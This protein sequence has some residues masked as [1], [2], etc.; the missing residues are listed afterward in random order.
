MDSNN[1]NSER[2]IYIVSVGGHHQSYL[3]ILGPMFGLSPITGRISFRLFNRL[4]NA[5]KLLFA[6]LDDDMFSFAAVSIA[7]SILRRPTVALFLRVQKCFEY[8]KWVYPAKRVAFR[9]LRR[10]RH[11]TIATITPFEVAPHYA[12]VAHVGLCDPQYWDLNNGTGFRKPGRTKLSEEVRERADGRKIC[13]VVGSL[14]IGKGIGFLAE[15]LE[16]YAETMVGV[17]V[18]CAGRVMPDSSDLITRLSECGA[19]IV[20]RFITDAELESLYGIADGVWAV[21]APDYD[22][23][24][25]VFGR[26]IQ[27]GVPVIVR[28]GS[29]IANF[30]KAMDVEHYPV[31]FDQHESLAAV[32]KRLSMAQVASPGRSE[33][34]RANLVGRWRQQFV[35]TIH[36][37]LAP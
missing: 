12:E 8:G 2:L 17:F 35:D 24:S 36:N 9:V 18:V 4:V 34:D 11:L 26:A 25:G 37:G 28:E 20:D 31:A 5:E 30:A 15:T 14:G 27:R 22:Q 33:F 6:S 10:L 13:I 3:D 32:L 23:A 16:L 7:R 19:L 1:E 29:V 21:Y